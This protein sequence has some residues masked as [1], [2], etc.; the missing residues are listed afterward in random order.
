MALIAG[1]T[2]SGKSALAL[3]LAEAED[4]VII[5]ADSAQIYRDIPILSAAPSDEDKARAEHRL[6]GVRDGALACSA[7]DWSELAK[8]EIG[9]AH[10]RGKLPILVGGTGAMPSRRVRR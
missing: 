4:G 7:A 6:Y 8:S 5:N 2:A 3:A 1:P 9:A 10:D